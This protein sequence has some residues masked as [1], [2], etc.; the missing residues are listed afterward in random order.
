LTNANLHPNDIDIIEAHGTGTT[1]GDPIEAQALMEVYGV[2]RDPGQPLY[3]GS[4]KSNIGHTQAAAGVGGI[5]KIVQ[6]LQNGVMPRTL[7]ADD[8]TPHIDWTTGAISLLTEAQPW[9]GTGTPRR[10]AVSSFGISGTNAH[11]IIEEPPAEVK[12]ADRADGSEP[13]RPIWVLSA[14]TEDELARAAG[15]LT[16]HATA[17]P[18]VTAGA[19]GDSLARRHQHP[20]RA[21]LHG[22]D[23]HELLTQARALA[24]GQA[25]PDLITGHAHDGKL[26]VLFTGQGAQY[27][28]MGRDLAETHP[29]FGELLTDIAGRFDHHLDHPLIDVMWAAPHTEL[30]ALLDRTRYTQPALFAFETAL[31]T[32]L[33]ERGLAPDY[34]MGHSIGEITAAHVAGTLSLD[35]AITLV[36]ARSRL[37]EGLPTD[38]GMLSVTAS[39]TDLHAVLDRHPEIDIAGHNSPRH[40]TLAG[41]HHALTTL[42][43]DLDTAGITHRPLTVSGAFHSR[44]LDPLLPQLTSAAE[45]LTHHA[46]TIPIV[47]NTTG[48]IATT[49]QLT[50][51]HHWATQARTAVHYHHG[52]TT[53]T[54]LGVT[55][56][57]EIGPDTTLTHLTRT[58]LANDTDDTT[59]TVTLIPTQNPRADRPDVLDDALATLHTVT[60]SGLT[61]PT[62]D[63]PPVALPTYPFTRAPYWLDPEPHTDASQIGLG[64]ADH[65]LLAAASELPDGTHLFTTTLTTGTHPWLAD[66]TIAGTTLLPGTAL[67]ELALHAGDLLTHPHLAELT[68]QSPIT[69]PAQLQLTVETPTDDQRHFTIHTRTPD[70]T[71]SSR[72]WILRATGTLTTAQPSPPDPAPT[73][74]PGEPA[75]L[76]GFYDVLSDHG[77]TYGPA[78]RGLDTHWPTTGWARA[79]L[80]TTHGRPT[81]YGIH[82]A[83]LDAALHPLV[84]PTGPDTPLRLPFTFNGVTAHPT[85][86]SE[87]LTSLRVRTTPHSAGADTYTVDAFTEGGTPVITIAGLTLATADPRALKASVPVPGLAWMPVELPEVS[88]NPDEAGGELPSDWVQIGGTDP[89]PGIT[90]HHPDLDALLAALADGA[91]APTTVLYQAPSGD[92]GE[93]GPEDGAGEEDE[94]GDLVAAVHHVTAAVL[95][96][97]Q[98]WLTVP[99]LADTRLTVLTTAATGPHHQD[100]HLPHSALT[101][102]LRTAHTENPDVV[103]HAD[104]PR[105]PLTP[106][107]VHN[108]RR[109]VAAR[110]PQFTLYGDAVL[111]PR[112]TPGTARGSASAAD[113]AQGTVLVTGGTGALG[114][115]TAR[116][117][118]TRPDVGRLVL[119]SRRGADAPG[120]RELIEELT[121]AGTPASVVACDVSDFSA[122][123]ALI[124]EVTA[125]GPLTGVV[126][127]AGTVSDATLPGL[128]QEQ[129]T[130]VLAA[131]VDAVWN[132]HRATVDQP[133]AAFVVYSSVAGLLGSSGQ[134]NYAAAN[135]FLDALAEHRHAQGHPA[136]SLAWGLWAE[137]MGATLDSGE[138]ARWAAA[139]MTPLSDAEG[140]ALLDAALGLDAPVLAP[141][142]WDRATLTALAQKDELPAVL[143]HMAPAPRRVSVPTSAA[144][145]Q[146]GMTR[147][148]E[149]ERVAAVREL[150]TRV[151]A[152]VLHTEPGRLTGDQAFKQLGFDSLT[153]VELRNRLN[154]ETGLRLATTLV[155]DH[156][157]PDALAAHITGLVTPAEVTPSTTAPVVTGGDADDD[158][159]VVV[160][161]ACRYPGGVTSPEELWQLVTDGT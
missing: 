122:V 148:S 151:C 105:T 29:R 149:V 160:S 54:T 47:T 86:M 121:A 130:S 112:L 83:L 154:R 111:A 107:A 19:I 89:L 4:L 11:V 12:P 137:G 17:R 106:D 141:V 59:D 15:R 58:T 27:P 123:R 129:L 38:T 51:P 81:G 13:D 55:T 98:T 117:L 136:T 161:M 67:L 90:T 73:V 50:D 155:F 61:W 35:D 49:E 3:L 101:G 65:P 42:A 93:G 5:I 43:Q 118:A 135:T 44:H 140:T 32:Y 131:K 1:L 46:P 97:L 142:R 10:A 7:H 78:F 20:Y 30:A 110:V 64:P 128:R 33:T 25:H 127:S 113:F 14:R 66:H 45:D 92:A 147:L 53:L 126:H 119:V 134:A 95:S 100:G 125:A 26:A 28:G 18:E 16:D 133:L 48:Q 99:A 124:A 62:T 108:L 91:P 144:T 114:A 84:A 85:G 139:G 116:Y 152:A 158:P 74:E 80:P 34:L 96:T 63:R 75:D 88:P 82:P 132:L 143:S 150:V 103:T 37:M 57:L 52:I 109:A 40:T 157:T 153:A 71:D 6:A 79:K 9:P 68:L 87:P 159:I 24:T 146:E 31:F 56:Y 69:L 115:V 22:A 120:S 8:P 36:A 21:V 145:W 70:A 77:Y 156:P 60:P 104:L 94:G 138:T 41:T 39:A 72:A 23:R 76:T 102:L 2:G